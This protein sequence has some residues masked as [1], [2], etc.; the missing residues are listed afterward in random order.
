VANPQQF[1]S[2]VPAFVSNNVF[3]PEGAQIVSRGSMVTASQLQID[4]IY[5]QANYPAL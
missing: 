2:G 1:A 4:I 3:Q 5:F